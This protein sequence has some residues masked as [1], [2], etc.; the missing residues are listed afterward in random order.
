MAAAM[1]ALAAEFAE[2]FS[3][4]EEEL[5]R[6]TDDDNLAGDA[7]SPQGWQA[8]HPQVLFATPTAKLL[9]DDH[10]A[11]NTYT[12]QMKNRTTVDLVQEAASSM[13]GMVLIA[14]F[15]E[16]MGKALSQAARVK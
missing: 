11:C 10:L 4:L 12:E 3:A 14:E 1:Q 16:H 15:D 6:S 9:A 8:Q 5:A 2:E 13:V 7:L